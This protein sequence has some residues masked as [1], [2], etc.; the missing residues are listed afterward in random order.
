MPDVRRAVANARATPRPGG[1]PLV[2]DV[3][4]TRPGVL[5]RLFR[6]LY[7]TLAGWSGEDVLTAPREAFPVGEVP[8]GDDGRSLVFLAVCMA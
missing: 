2:L 1:R 6:W 3:R 4:L 5:A 8:D 7:R